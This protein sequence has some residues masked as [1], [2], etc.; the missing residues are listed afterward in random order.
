M[1]VAGRN[2][3]K[4][5]SFCAD[6]AGTE[7]VVADRDGDIGRLL[8]ERRPDLLID[9]AGPFQGSGQQVPLACIRASVPYLDL[10]DARGFVTGIAALDAA[11]RAAGVAVVAGASSVPALSGAVARHLAESLDAV[12]DVEIAIS[13]SNR[14]TSG[15]SVAAAILSYVGRPIRLWRGRRWTRG[16]GWQELRRK[17][18]AI[19]GEPALEGRWLA[20]ADVPDHDLMPD[21]LAGRPAVTFRAGTDIALQTLGLWLLSWPVR[22]LGVKSLARLAFIV[23][24][25]QRLT[26]S[27]GSERSAMSV[28]LRGVAG[29]RGIERRWTLIA[30]DG[31]GPEIP[32]LATVLLA[33][34]ILAGTIRPGAR[35]AGRLLDLEQ[36]D[37]L[38]SSLSIRHQAVDTDLPPPL[39]ERVMGT[40][41]ASLPQAV[42][43]MHR[44]HADSGAS[45]EAI[46]ERG[47]NFVARFIARALRFP[48]AG[49]HQLHVAFTERD[50]VETWTREFGPHSF[51]SRLSERNGQL[52]ERFGPLRFRFDLPS[53]D[54]GLAMELRGWDCLGIPL[55]MALAPRSRAREWQED[56]RFRLDVPIALPLVGLIVHYTGW[57]E[58]VRTGQP[59]NT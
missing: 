14:A 39:Y 34:A 1:L 36:F 17:T 32:T 5:A 41:Y 52:V 46:V 2:V 7:P 53:D 56:G 29:D 40:R 47:H 13:A 37:P 11:A 16:W 26:H 59:S 44:V 25:L 6:V 15:R 9:A 19:E 38:F 50:G 28:T 22:W 45:G 54:S 55:P 48:P 23:P 12:R 30:N 20:L 51:T 8:A 42:R 31:D 3:G 18:F 24:P 49:R 58:P 43:E 35:D 4:A 33:E 57:L 10:A 21:M 27:L